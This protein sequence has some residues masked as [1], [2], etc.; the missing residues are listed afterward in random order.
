MT[1]KMR[2]IERGIANNR[3]GS[4]LAGPARTTVVVLLST[5][6]TIHETTISNSSSSCSGSALA[7]P[8]RTT[9]QYYV[10]T[11]TI[12]KTAKASRYLSYP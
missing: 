6:I 8:A 12:S 5:T 10:R 3:S 9:A 11:F 2:I 1:S 4:A 7:G